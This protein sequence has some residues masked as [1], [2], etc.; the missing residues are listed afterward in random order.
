MI[1]NNGMRSYPSLYP[2]Q[3]VGPF[4]PME[5]PQG[6][7]LSHLGEG[8]NGGVRTV[9]ARFLFVAVTLCLASPRA[10]SANLSPEEQAYVTEQSNILLKETLT[11]METIAQR[12][13]IPPVR[14]TAQ[15]Q[16]AR[17]APDTFPPEKLIPVIST[18]LATCNKV[19]TPEEKQKLTN[20][21]NQLVKELRDL[22]IIGYSYCRS[23]G[24]AYGF[25]IQI[26]R[27]VVTY[28]DFYGT[29]KTRT[30]QTAF[31]TGGLNFEIAP[32]LN[33]IFFLGKDDNFYDSNKFIRLG[34]GIE[35]GGPFC[36]LTYVPFK[37][38]TGGLLIVALSPGL[39]SPVALSVIP[40][41]MILTPVA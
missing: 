30:Y 40:P 1:L 8:S 25:G 34:L 24:I 17:K 26:L 6:V 37:N 32:R 33:F 11:C 38:T 15:L 31:P 41:G 23:V 36:R 28:K 21:K 12:V 18:A 19:M 27:F 22:K 39:T 3:G 13:S 9:V 16:A 2:I 29:A 20:V 35:L 4:A 14:L 5:N 10:L 7:S